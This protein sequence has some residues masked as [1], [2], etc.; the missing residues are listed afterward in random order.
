MCPSAH[1]KLI[2]E[3]LGKWTFIRAQAAAVTAVR[4]Q[5]DVGYAPGGYQ[6]THDQGFGGWEIP[7]FIHFRFQISV[8]I[9]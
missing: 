4:Q 1:R 5:L 8:L 3:R 9:S 2:G 6:S 7:M